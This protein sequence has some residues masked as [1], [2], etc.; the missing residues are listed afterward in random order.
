MLIGNRTYKNISRV[1]KIAGLPYPIFGLVLVITYAANMVLVRLGVSIFVT[2]G[3]FILLYA[4]SYYL[5][6][7]DE[8]WL[9]TLLV[10]L[11]FFAGSVGKGVEYEP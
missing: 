3:L 1:I 7:K 8:R 2:L 11:K 6:R 10:Y 4:G 9:E 5:T